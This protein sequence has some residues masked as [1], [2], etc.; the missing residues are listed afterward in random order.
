MSSSP[1]A[2][3]VYCGGLD[4][5]SDVLESLKPKKDWEK[6]L[7]EKKEELRI[8]IIDALNE[9]K[10][11]TNVGSLFKD[12]PTIIEI[13]AF[14]PIIL[15]FK[16]PSELQL[17]RR[18]KII[19]GYHT[20]YVEQ[21]KVIYDG[22]LLMIAAPCSLKERPTGV[23]DVRDRFIRMLE[24]VTEPKLIPPCLTHHAF[25]LTTSKISEKEIEKYKDVYI[26]VKDSIMDAIRDL[27]LGIK[28]KMSIFY[29][30]CTT[31]IKIEDLK[32]EVVKIEKS[33][34]EDL[35]ELEICKWT[36]FLKKRHLLRKIKMHIMN[37]L[38]RLSEYSSLIQEHQRNIWNVIECMG[39][40]L[41][42]RNFMENNNWLEYVEAEPLNVEDLIRIIEYAH[43][44]MEVHQI[45]T[46]EL[47]AAL[48]GGLA[49]ASATL[50]LS[51]ILNLLG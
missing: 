20:F 41:I 37:I 21:F 25:I 12:P 3:A 49:G 51:Y 32:D 24:S 40:N 38:A 15:D 23:F 18:S 34:L 31:K 14:N 42:F 39:G 6:E 50:I 2:I 10:E 1:E 11:V 46:S 13:G 8:R 28:V 4:V 7:Q 29:S 19:S 16:L 45:T 17:S 36:N 35:R 44:E 22:E 9:H 27:Y 30:A 43:R 5:L 26:V 48:V 33:L 47:K